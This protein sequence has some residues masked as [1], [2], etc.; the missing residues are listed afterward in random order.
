M[1]TESK[2][3]K[4]GFDQ[5]YCSLCEAFFDVKSN[6]SSARSLALHARRSQS[7]KSKVQALQ[8]SRVGLPSGCEVHNFDENPEIFEGPDYW[9]INDVLSRDELIDGESCL[10]E[11][12]EDFFISEEASKKDARMQFEELSECN[13]EECEEDEI[14]ESEY[15]G[16]SDDE[17]ARD[18]SI[19]NLYSCEMNMIL[20]TS[21]VLERELFMKNPT[22]FNRVCGE[23]VDS[24]IALKILEKCESLNL[25]QGESN[26]LLELFHEV[27]EKTSGKFLPL[28]STIQTL[29]KSVFSI[30]DST[31]PLREI[32]LKILPEFFRNEA[33]SNSIKS[34]F[35]KYIPIESALAELFLRMNPKKNFWKMEPQ[36]HESKDGTP[37]RIWSGWH[38]SNYAVELQEHILSQYSSDSD[39]TSTPFILYVSVF[40][41]GGSMNSTNTRSATPV[42]I[43]VLNS[44]EALSSLVGFIPSMNLSDEEVMAIFA[45]KGFNKTAS[46]YLLQLIPRQLLWDYVYEVFGNFMKNQSTS[47]GFD[48]QI[49]LGDEKEFH[50]VH[51][52]V[53]N[54]LGDFPQ[55]ADLSGISRKSCRFCECDDFSNFFV[56]SPDPDNID[57]EIARS[58]IRQYEISKLS[59]RMKQ[60]FICKEPGYNEKENSD[61]RIEIE[62]NRSQ[63]NAYSGKN[64]IYKLFKFMTGKEG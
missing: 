7:H 56:P 50:K 21:L 53:T 14:A 55:M 5:V 1:N 35:A 18:S 17:V 22:R 54:F 40:I 12:D 42:I 8:F 13:G 31:V 10:S 3:R 6:G 45:H 46:K 48:V 39:N 59:G 58:V 57:E 20:E 23:P 43:S 32:E 61:F 63:F 47:G 41:D 64:K 34:I 28:P 38:S 49:G 26:G 15:I 60:A 52:V 4:S 24:D 27:V 51:V 29:K 36:Y 9:K 19:N 62:R 33:A 2:K 11:F 16:T 30:V 25:S 44:E 37:E